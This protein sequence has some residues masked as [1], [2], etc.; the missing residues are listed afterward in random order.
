MERPGQKIRV[1]SHKSNALVLR[2]ADNQAHTFKSAFSRIFLG[3]H[4]IVDARHKREDS[5]V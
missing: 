1:T 5:M 4:L 2:D 3:E